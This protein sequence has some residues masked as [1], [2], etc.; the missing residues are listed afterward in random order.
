MKTRHIIINFFLPGTTFSICKLS[1]PIRATL[2]LLI[3]LLALSLFSGRLPFARVEASSSSGSPSTASFWPEI[4]WYTVDAGGGA[5]E[6]GQYGVEGTVAQ[7][8]ASTSL[9]GGKFTLQGGFWGTTQH[10]LYLPRV[11]K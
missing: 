8:D 5:S 3:M 11:R 4:N 6:L 9:I 7:P 10:K 2:L 1:R